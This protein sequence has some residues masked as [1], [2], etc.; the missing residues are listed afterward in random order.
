MAKHKPDWN[1][2][3]CRYHFWQ[4]SGA[5][6]YVGGR[7]PLLETRTKLKEQ[8]EHNK[9]TNK[10]EKLNDYNKLVLAR[11]EFST[12]T[13]FWAGI[14]CFLVEEFSTGKFRVSLSSTSRELMKSLFK[15]GRVIWQTMED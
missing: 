1:G 7:T 12:V 14:E 5:M 13:M 15:S 8:K 2:A 10:L 4:R 3:Y 6:E 11:S 9:K